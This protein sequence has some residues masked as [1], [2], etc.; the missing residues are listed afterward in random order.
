MFTKLHISFIIF[1]LG[2]NLSC[3]LRN[4]RDKLHAKVLLFFELTKSCAK[5]VK[6]FILLQHFEA[7]IGNVAPAMLKGLTEKVLVDSVFC[8]FVGGYGILR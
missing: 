1:G 4:K 7:K 6:E 2:V 3:F 5:N 8:Y